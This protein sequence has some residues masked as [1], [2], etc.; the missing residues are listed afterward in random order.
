VCAVRR[1]ARLSEDLMRSVG[2]LMFAL[3]AIVLLSRKSSGDGHWS[4]FAQFLVVMVPTTTLYA[5]AVLGTRARASR[6]AQPDQTVLAVTALLLSP[7]AF[8]EFLRWVGASTDGALEIAGVFAAA[9]LVAAFATRRAG[10]S[11][12]AFLAGLAALVAWLLVWDKILDHPSADTFRWLLIA[13]A[14]LLVVTAGG[15][16]FAGARGASELATAAGLAAVSAGIIGVVVSAL[17]GVGHA[18]TLGL[19]PSGESASHAPVLPHLSGAQR[20]GW[21]IYLLTVSLALIWAGSRAR[22]RGLGYVGALGVLAFIISVAAEVARFASGHGRSH[23]IAGW[24]L[25]LLIAGAVALLAGS[26]GRTFRRP[27]GG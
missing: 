13:G 26:L 10:V 15:L 1:P 19:S 9:A 25:V 24:P 17:L 11:Y 20:L 16:S 22:V 8:L 23:D 5:L 6:P 12:A 14:A 18:I 21:D 4:H 3:G 27:A 2:G 7:L